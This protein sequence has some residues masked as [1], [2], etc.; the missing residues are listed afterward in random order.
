[1]C[2][3]VLKNARYSQSNA[4]QVVFAFLEFINRHKLTLMQRICDLLVLS[5][6]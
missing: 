4:E 3:A 5:T 1:L 6:T 2:I